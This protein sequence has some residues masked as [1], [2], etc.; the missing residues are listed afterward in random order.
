MSDYTRHFLNGTEIRP[1]NA[2]N[3]G[4]KI[5]WTKNPDEAELTVDSIILTNQAKTIVDDHIDNGAGFFEGIPYRVE[6]D[7]L[8]VDYYVDLTQNSKFQDSKYEVNIKRRKALD[9]FMQQADG[10]SFELLKARNA[11]NPS[12]FFDVPYVIIR[13]NQGELLIMLSITTYQLSLALADAAQQFVEAITDLLETLPPVPGNAGAIIA[14]AV[15][16]AAR[17]IY[18]AA[19]VLALINLINQIKEILFPSLR[20]FKAA[21]FKRLLEVG[22]TN[23]GYQFQSNLM[24]ELERLTLLPVPMQ[25]TNNSIFDNL[26][27]IQNQSYTKGYPTALDTVRTLGDLIREVEKIGNAKTRVINGT[28]RIEERTFWYTQSGITILNT[29]NVQQDRENSKTYN[30]GEAWKRYYLHAQIDPTDIHTMDKIDKTDC[31]YSTEPIT[32]VNPDLVLI[33]GL[34]EMPINFAY[35]IRKDNLTFVENIFLGLAQF[36]DSV[37]NFFGGNSNLAA[38][39]Q[40]RIGV[41]QISQQHFRITKMMWCSPNGKQPPNYMDIIGAKPLYQ[42]RHTINQVR[43]NFKEIQKATVPFSAQ[44]F[45]NLLDNNVVFDQDG[46]QLEILTFEWINETREA[47]IEYTVYS[48][49]ANNVQTIEIDG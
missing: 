12:D 1:K 38:G 8:G 28:V 49:K 20:Y 11:F 30:F 27:G 42:A 47:E 37:V 45:I 19:I 18:L 43:E 36:A 26:M 41:L 10:L 32:V 4:F 22:C 29:L 5:D 9:Y 16:A 3:L 35:G 17:F 6:I 33:K 46:T 15:K 48:D 21:Y 34:V 23:L 31:E 44:N 24:N 14:A 39:I 2:E 7:G 40:G 25:D 13:D